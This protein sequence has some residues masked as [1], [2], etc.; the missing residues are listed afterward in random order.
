[1]RARW[2]KNIQTKKRD[3]QWTTGEQET[4]EQKQDEE[5]KKREQKKE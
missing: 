2:L 5:Q 4:A 3:P 1:V